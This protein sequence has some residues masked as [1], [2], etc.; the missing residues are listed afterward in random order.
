[1]GAKLRSSAVAATTGI[2]GSHGGREYESRADSSA[3]ETFW[4]TPQR[5]SSTSAC[6]S[7]G[8]HLRIGWW[9]EGRH[10]KRGQLGMDGGSEAAGQHGA[11]MSRPEL[12]Q[13]YGSRVAAIIVVVRPAMP[14]L[15]QLPLTR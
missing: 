11:L 6:L 13:F 15:T 14:L 5:A 8:E 3:E 7:C 9:G 12:L 2:A 4:I 10:D 1:M